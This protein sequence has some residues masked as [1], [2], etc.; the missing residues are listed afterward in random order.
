M[1]KN[2]EYIC[3]DRLELLSNPLSNGR[4]IAAL[5][6][7]ILSHRNGEEIAKIEKKYQAVVAESIAVKNE[8]ICWAKECDR[9]VHRYTNKITDI[10]QSQAV[11]EL[12]EI[13]KETTLAIN[14]IEARGID[15]WIASRNGRWNGTTKEAEEFA[16]SLRGGE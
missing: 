4:L 6:I 11:N 1:N 15:K 9:I 10:H 3:N 12:G 13:L 2:Y 16:A 8:V 5:S 14:G 7:E